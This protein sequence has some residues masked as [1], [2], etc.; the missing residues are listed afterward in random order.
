MF[1]RRAPRSGRALRNCRRPRF[2]SP[3]AIGPEGRDRKAAKVSMVLVAVIAR[4]RGAT[5]RHLNPGDRR[6]RNGRGS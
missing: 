2:E 6:L 3:R 4:L 1:L 5:Y